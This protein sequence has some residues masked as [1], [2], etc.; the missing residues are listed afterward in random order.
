MAIYKDIWILFQIVESHSI[1]SL[2]EELAAKSEQIKQKEEMILCLQDELIK[3][4][5]REAENEEAIRKLTEK[6]SELEEVTCLL[7]G[8]TCESPFFQLDFVEA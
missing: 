7:L 6:I 5:L 4:R 2:E 8:R 3:V 1:Q